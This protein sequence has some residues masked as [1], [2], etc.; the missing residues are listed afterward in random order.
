MKRLISVVFISVLLL[1]FFVDT[2]KN[3][4][5]VGKSVCIDPGHGGSEVGTS[6][7]GILEKDLN[8][9][10]ANRLAYL[11]TQSGLTVYQT[12]TG[13]ETLSNR[14]RYTFCNSKNA[15]ILVSI[16]HNGSNDFSLDYSQALYM[17]KT[18]VDLAKTIVGSVSAKLGTKNWGISRF[19]SGVLLKAKMPA[20]ISEG[21]FLTSSYE[22]DLLTGTIVDRRQDEAQGLFEGITA[23]FVTH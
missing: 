13:D 5:A 21:F 8:L 9:D 10:V 16:H 14:D 17:K 7:N 19:A 11:A 6:N 12:R 15:G 2:P 23:Y 3:V 1:F 22:Y 18:D 4:D 20:T